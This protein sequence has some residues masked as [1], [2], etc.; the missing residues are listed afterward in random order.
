[1]IVEIGIQQKYPILLGSTL[2]FMMGNGYDL[3]KETFDRFCEFLDKCK[4]YDEDAKQF[5]EYWQEREAEAL[6]KAKK[7][8]AA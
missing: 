5:R 4:G 1:M 6:A 7:T 8:E 2:K 3:K